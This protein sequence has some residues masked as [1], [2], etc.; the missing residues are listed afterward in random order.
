MVAVE[1]GVG[2]EVVGVE[3]EVA[4]VV[5]GGGPPAG[6]GGG[7]EEEVAA[8]VV[9]SGGDV[10][11]LLHFVL[12]AYLL[13]LYSSFELCCGGVEFDRFFFFVCRPGG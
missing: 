2:E 4:A 13:F 9:E 8:C 11:F 3:I 12:Q 5:A 10:L 6:S 1:E 7:E